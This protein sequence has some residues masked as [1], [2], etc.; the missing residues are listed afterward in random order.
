MFNNP[1]IFSIGQVTHSE[2]L[3]HLRLTIDTKEDLIFTRSIYQK[4]TSKPILLQDIVQILK[5]NP[6]IMKINK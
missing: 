4:I 2:N 5:D 6:E 3:S 1:K